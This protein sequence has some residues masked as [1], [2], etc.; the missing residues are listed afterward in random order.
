M[1]SIKLKWVV[2]VHRLR[3][4]RRWADA[5][6]GTGWLA[7][8]D[9]AA[10]RAADLR[11]HAQVLAHG[12]TSPLARDDVRGPGDGPW[13]LPP[14]VR[15]TSR[16]EVGELAGPSTGWPPTSPR[17]NSSAGSSSRTC[18]TSSALPS[19]RCGRSWRTSPTAS[20]RPPPR[21]CEGALAQTERLGRLV[22]QLLDLSRV[23]AGAVSLDLA[24]F[25]IGPFLDAA[26]ADAQVGHAVRSS[27]YGPN[28]V[29]PSARTA[30]ACTR[31]SP[32][33]STT[34]RG[35]ARPAAR[36]R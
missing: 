26:I 3:R 29:S 11:S 27:P 10:R 6:G 15:V 23:E 34:R 22:T 8:P 5:G 20:P 24:S 28:P 17:S 7:G 9:H 13:R 35:T 18:H 32:T 12:M 36:S 33:C 4:L 2:V 21:S 30:T 19:P 16:D 14:R 31:S 1:R 25:E